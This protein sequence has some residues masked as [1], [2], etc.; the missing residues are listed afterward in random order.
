MFYFRSLYVRLMVAYFIIILTALSV[1]GILLSTFFQRYIMETSKEE[2]I[3]EGKAISQ[4]I[5]L[6]L[7]GYIDSSVLHYQ[8]QII[9]RFLGTTIWVTDE[10]GYIWSSHN[11][12]ML[13]E[14]DWDNQKV[15]VDEF[16]QVLSGET[17]TR[18]GK[19]SESFPVPVLTVGMPWTLNNKI[20]GTIFLHSPLEGINRTLRDTY[21]SIWRSAILTSIFSMIL[22]YFISRR[23][24]KPL[25]EMNEISREIATGNFKRRVK[26]K[27]R[28]EV[29]QLAVNFNA[30]ADS[31]EKLEL[32][33][34]SFVAN[35]SHE[36]RSPLTSMRG[37]IQGVLDHAISGE[38]QEKYLKIALEETERM[39]RLINDLLDLSQIQTGNFS[40]Q[41]KVVDIN[42]I[43]RRILI[44]REDRILD[45]NMDVDVD[46]EKDVFLVKG[47]PD[48]LKQVVINLMDNA[49]KYNREGGLLS[50]KTWQHKEN[51]YVKIADEGPGISKEEIAHI[52][53]PFYQ[54]DKSRTQKKGG[55]GLGLSIVKKIIEAHDQKI[56][57]N[58]QEGKG[59][60]F[61]FSLQSVKNH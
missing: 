20:R 18:I 13:E 52:W 24:S 40:M 61:I 30:M 46:F 59:S 39:N 44:E 12:A 9:D 17:I 41:F 43:I 35:V 31:L 25:T 38:G 51:V 54:V 49:I 27:T 15:T 50:I 10:L 5:N 42:E 3:R 37:Y 60:A 21:Q 8:Y 32:M 48:R 53:E 47:D 29:G 23:F 28:D 36:L 34:R 2:L 4:Y 55:V 56:W 26:V 6:Y 58:S 11:S 19:F 16:T 22:L 45:K 14:V 33:R 7:K 1:L 57:L